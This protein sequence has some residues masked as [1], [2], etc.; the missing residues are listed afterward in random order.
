MEEERRRNTTGNSVMFQFDQTKDELFPSSLNGFF[1]DIPH[2]KC[3]MVTFDLPTL[4][5][6]HLVPG[7]LDG[8]SLGAAALAG[9]PSLS[10]LEHRAELL[11]H[12]VNVF[13]SASRN[14]SIIIYVKNTHRDKKPVDIAV[15]MI[16][17][18]TFIGWPFLR[19]GL[20]TAISD[21]LFRYEAPMHTTKVGANNVIA[22]P[23]SPTG[24]HTWKR[25][26]EQIEETYSKRFGVIIE[27]VEVLLHVS[28]IKGEHASC[29]HLK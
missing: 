16:G 26:A 7:L 24:V 27:S 15:E 9:F 25:K 6:L 4:D 2:C 3:A 22:N 17:K 14:K 12:G 21:S 11:P 23:H 18:R 1:P 19:E 28:P 29:G 10:T 13:Q 5:G 8:V 20:V